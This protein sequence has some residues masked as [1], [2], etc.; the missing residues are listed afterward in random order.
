MLDPLRQQWNTSIQRTATP[1][2]SVF[3][4]VTNC[5]QTST[6][7][8][9]I[10][11][12][13]TYPAGDKVRVTF[14]LR[15]GTLRT[16]NNLKPVLIIGK[17]CFS[18]PSR[19][20]RPWRKALQ[21]IDKDRACPVKLGEEK[22]GSGGLTKTSFTFTK[23]LPQNT[24]TATWF[25]RVYVKCQNAQ[26]GTEWCQYDGSVNQNYIGTD[27]M[28]AVGTGMIAAVIICAAIGPVFLVGHFIVDSRR[29]KSK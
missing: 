12:L 27:A 8:P 25:A 1:D 2:K 10:L 4:N 19:F 23:G 26:N 14:T 18:P 15:N 6:S 21:N 20:D 24:P 13:L 3:V 16:R 22:L 17:L 5:N 9:C 29:R 11:P 28:N 7:A